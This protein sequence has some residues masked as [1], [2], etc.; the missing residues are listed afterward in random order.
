M[1]CLQHQRLKWYLDR[2]SLTSGNPG[3]TYLERMQ[4]GEK[5]W[6]CAIFDEIC[7]ECRAWNTWILFCISPRVSEGGRY[8][9]QAHKVF[10]AKHMNSTTFFSTMGISSNLITKLQRFHSS[11]CL[12]SGNL[13]TRNIDII[14]RFQTQSPQK[15]NFAGTWSIIC[16]RY[17][18][19]LEEHHVGRLVHHP[20]LDLLHQPG[21][22]PQRA[23]HEPGLTLPTGPAKPARSG[24]GI[25][26]RFGRKPVQTGWI[27]IWIQ[28]SQC[29]R[30]GPVYRPVRPV[31][32]PVWPVYH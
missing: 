7:R 28:K 16:H 32:R 3:S 26:V 2:C 29:N 23:L 21:L 17:F 22:D 4:P 25:P 11:P 27:Q 20:P 14:L 15:S 18:P 24:T 5:G 30:F 1:T 13:I 9:Y 31:Y 6:L 19:R 10:S 12:R 8:V